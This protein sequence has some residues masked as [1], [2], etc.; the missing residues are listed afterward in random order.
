MVVEQ[1]RHVSKLVELK[2]NPYTGSVPFGSKA[3]D[4]FGS[5]CAHVCTADTVGPAATAAGAR[6]ADTAYIVGRRINR[7]RGSGRRCCHGSGSRRVRVSRDVVVV[8]VVVVVAVVVGI[9]GAATVII[10][11]DIAELVVI[12]PL[13]DARDIAAA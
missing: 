4:D 2:P 8:V 9:V 5:G 7:M 11:L 10:V 12:G 1:R 6:S 13:A 3:Y